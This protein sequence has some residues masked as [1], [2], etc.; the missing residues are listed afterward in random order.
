MIRPALTDDLPDILR[1][2]SLAKQD[3]LANGNP[4]WDS[5]YPGEKEYASDIAREQLFVETDDNN[6]VR[7][8]MCLNRD[9]HEAYSRLAWKTPPPSLSIHRIAVHTGFRKSGIARSLFLF[10]EEYARDKGMR[11]IRLDTFSLNIS[12]Q[13]L[14]VRMGYEYAGDIYMKGRPL[15]YRCYEKS[16]EK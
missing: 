12:A 16:V 10:A 2:V 14:F 11:S 13:K 8:V 15:P 3:M 5:D 9:F 1:I 6:T 4:Q 7:A